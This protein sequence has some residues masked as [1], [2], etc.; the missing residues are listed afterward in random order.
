MRLIAAITDRPTIEHLLTHLD[1][2]PRPLPL[3]PARGPPQAERDFDQ[4]PMAK[5]VEVIPDYEFDQRISW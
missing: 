1:Q 2:M 3:S 4:R 5:A